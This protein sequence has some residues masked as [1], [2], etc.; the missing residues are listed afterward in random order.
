MTF[1]T[2]WTFLSRGQNCTLDKKIK[3]MQ[4]GPVKVKDARTLLTTLKI[5]FLKITK[6]CL[7]NLPKS[8]NHFGLQICDISTLDTDL[9]LPFSDPKITLE[10]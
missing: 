10:R 9:I 5:L 8:E 1:L 3:G 7:Q 2:F 4:L 6:E